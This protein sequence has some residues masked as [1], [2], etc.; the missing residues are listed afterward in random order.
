MA[1]GPLLVEFERFHHRWGWYLALGL[2]LVILGA[3]ALFLVPA[4]TL[5]TVLVLGWLLVISGI[6][7]CVHAFQMRR[8][9]GVFLHLVGGILGVVVGLLVVMHPVAGALAWTLLFASFFT[10][11]GIFRIVAAARL[12]FPFWGW[13]VFDGAVTTLLGLILWVS[14]PWSGLWFLGVALGVSLILRGWSYVMLSI[15]A[16][17]SVATPGPEAR[18]AA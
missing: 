6:I 3:I 5:A 12:K 4:A 7:E 2:V 16:R 1:T 14:W 8:W 13:A 10:V 15:A 17:A 9:G 11:V 18:R